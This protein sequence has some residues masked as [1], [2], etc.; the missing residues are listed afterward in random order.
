MLL[1]AVVFVWS[2]L[3][4]CYGRSAEAIAH[5]VERQRDPVLRQKDVKAAEPGLPCEQRPLR[6]RAAQQHPG[7]SG[8]W[9][10]RLFSFLGTV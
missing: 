2:G 8:C 7:Q 9:N 1:V 3:T 10:N 4:V 5:T 6:P